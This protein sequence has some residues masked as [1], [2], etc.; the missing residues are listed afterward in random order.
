[1]GGVAG[2]IIPDRCTVTVNYR[3]APDKSVSEAVDHVRELFSGFEVVVVDEAPG[4]RPGLTNTL[5]QDFVAALGLDAS[6]KYGWTDVAR[7]GEWG[8]PALNYGPGDP[9]LAHSDDERVDIAQI[10]ACY[11]ALK[12]WLSPQ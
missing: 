5:V 9:S 7:F 2:N 6:A 10:E 1:A 3:F 4:A 8:I 11:R 12:S